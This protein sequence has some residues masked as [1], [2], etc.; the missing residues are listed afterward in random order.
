MSFVSLIEAPLKQRG[1]ILIEILAD[2]DMISIKQREGKP[3]DVT[4]TSPDSIG[5]RKTDRAGDGP[6]CGFPLY[7]LYGPGGRLFHTMERRPAMGL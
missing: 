6:C 3:R 1:T 2:A 7:V 5:R 4:G